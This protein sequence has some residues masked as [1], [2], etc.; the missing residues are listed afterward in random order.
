M[1]GLPAV[2]PQPSAVVLIT[3]QSVP[4]HLVH[5]VNLAWV[6]SVVL[7]VEQ[8]WESELVLPLPGIYTHRVPINE[9]DTGIE[10]M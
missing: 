3:R 10:I 1:V 6:E 5:R 9:V 8:V 7:V 2:I 4:V